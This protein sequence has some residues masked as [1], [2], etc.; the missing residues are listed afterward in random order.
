[1][2]YPRCRLASDYMTLNYTVLPR[3]RVT[4][5]NFRAGLP[6][7]IAPLD[8]FFPDESRELLGGSAHRLRFDRRETLFQCRRL[9]RLVDL[10]IELH[11]DRSR[12]PHGYHD[13][14]PRIG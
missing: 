9:Q 5:I 10:S 8:C 7:D 14:S 12:R 2:L 13:A 1:M 11:D 3:Q 6:D 4:S